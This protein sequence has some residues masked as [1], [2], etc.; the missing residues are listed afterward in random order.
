MTAIQQ[1]AL[2][3]KPYF[4]KKLFLRGMAAVLLFY[5]CIFSYVAMTKDGLF[6]SQKETLP[7]KTVLIEDNM[8]VPALAGAQ[9]D[10]TTTAK[11]TASG[12]K[13]VSQKLASFPNA[14]PLEAVPVTGLYET[15]NAG[16]KPIKRHADGLS[17]FEAYKRP[18]DKKANEDKPVISLGLYNFGISKIASESALRSL[19]PE[20]SLIM[21]PYVQDN[22]DLVRQARS[23]GHEVWLTLP[24]ETGSY[25]RFDPGPHTLMIQTPLQDNKN[26]LNWI[27]T[28]SVGYVGFIAPYDPIFLTSMSDVRPIV[29]DIANRGLAFMNTS[30]YS[31][32]SLE[33]IF[34]NANS[35]YGETTTWIDRPETVDAITDQLKAL[36]E[37]AKAKGFASAL[38]RPLPVTYQ[39]IL[40]WTQTLENKGF[41]L[42]PLSA[43]VTQ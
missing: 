1:K 27:L 9:S 39:Q 15:T 8:S 41:V 31:S 11:T 14:K 4:S 36:E 29:T 20:I 25:P 22:E 6:Q 28:S 26:K 40:K 24:I 43:Q 37:E 30:D 19:P 42:A 12:S 7:S 18:F 10:T 38:F 35:Y 3:L 23:L 13:T 34:L 33:S 16:L 2:S 17:P 21:S 5:V 32:L